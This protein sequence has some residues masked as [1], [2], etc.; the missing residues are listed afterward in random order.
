MKTTSYTLHAVLI[1]FAGG[2][3]A[4]EIEFNR[5]IR[6]ILSESCFHCHGPSKKGRKAKLRLDV[7]E[8]AL[9]E[10]DGVRAIVP[11]KPK[12]SE[13]LTRVASSDPDERMPPSDSKKHPLKKEQVAWRVK[14]E[15]FALKCFRLETPY[16]WERHHQNPP[17]LHNIRDDVECFR[18][19]CQ[20]LEHMKESNCIKAVIFKI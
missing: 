12:L 6:P 1:F 20:V 9:K 17:W 14:V 19:L 3:A 5:D 15:P 7:S 18:W 2:I 16:V 13:L 11:G 10:R 8:S 4:A